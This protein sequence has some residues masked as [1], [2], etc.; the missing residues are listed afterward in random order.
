[1]VLAQN[2]Q[3]DQWD[4]IEDWVMKPHNYTHIIFD[5]GAKNIQ[6]GKDRLFDKCCWEK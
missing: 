5:K 2:R 4:R 1:M 6:W 3:E